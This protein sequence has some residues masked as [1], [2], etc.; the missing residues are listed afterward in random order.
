MAPPT[1]DGHVDTTCSWRVGL[2]DMPSDVG[3][4]RDPDLGSS[5]GS[6]MTCF[7][8]LS[9]I[10]IFSRVSICSNDKMNRGF[11]LRS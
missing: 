10:L 5:L 6:V 8:T 11:L 4:R 2:W 1:S 9:K 3:W 7:V